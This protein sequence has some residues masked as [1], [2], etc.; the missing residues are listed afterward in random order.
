MWRAV[1][2][3]TGTPSSS[4]I[5][6]NRSAS[7]EQWQ[8]MRGSIHPSRMLKGLPF[9]GGIARLLTSHDSIN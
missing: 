6:L 7:D 1:D 9:L 8:R 4:P 2:D 3:I 5:N